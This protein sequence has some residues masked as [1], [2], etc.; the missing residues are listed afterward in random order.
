M[1]KGFCIFYLQM[2]Q[3]RKESVNYKQFCYEKRKRELEEE[4]QS[5]KVRYQEP[6]FIDISSMPGKTKTQDQQQWHIVLRLNGGIELELSSV[7]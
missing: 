6:S 1:G 7:Q 4:P 2:R 5:T 3:N